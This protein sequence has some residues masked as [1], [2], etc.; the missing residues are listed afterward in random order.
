MRLLASELKSSSPMP[1][2]EAVGLN[3]QLKAIGAFV[4][5]NPA[6]NVTQKEDAL[7]LVNKGL[8]Y[9]SQSNIDAVIAVLSELRQLPQQ[10]LS[11]R[12]GARHAIYD[13]QD[14]QV[15]DQR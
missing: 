5:S 13:G 11:E 3:T 10:S 2:L 7:S 1:V 14:Y 6:I 8:N 12:L 15:V 4:S 9:L